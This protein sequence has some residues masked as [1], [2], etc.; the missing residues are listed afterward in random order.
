M[1]KVFF[2]QEALDFAATLQAGGVMASVYRCGMAAYLTRSCVYKPGKDYGMAAEYV[3][4][5]RATSGEYA[6]GGDEVSFGEMDRDHF[7]VT[8]TMLSYYGLQGGLIGASGFVSDIER[9]SKRCEYDPADITCKA[10]VYA[11][12]M[13]GMIKP[14]ASRLMHREIPGAELIMLPHHGHATIMLEAPR[15]IRAL[16]EGRSVS[17]RHAVDDAAVAAQCVEGVLFDA[18][19]F[20]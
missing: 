16:V 5:P 12:E 6:E 8:K 11:G 2:P 15:V 19:V 9:Q 7:F 10:F 1:R 4:T 14:L 17:S 18:G 20:V 3:N 13:D